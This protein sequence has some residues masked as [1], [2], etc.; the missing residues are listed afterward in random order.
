VVLQLIQQIR[1]DKE[2]LLDRVGGT[3]DRFKNTQV[4]P[5]HDSNGISVGVSIGS[6]QFNWGLEWGGGLQR[7]ARA[8]TPA[9]DRDSGDP[10]SQVRRCRCR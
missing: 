6:L 9:S 8:S 4:R 10:A 7:R 5:Q 1:A 3:L 2:A